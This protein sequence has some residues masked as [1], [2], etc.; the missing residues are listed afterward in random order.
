MKNIFY[1][2]IALLFTA[3][4]CQKVIDLKVNDA[5]PKMVIEAKYDAIKEIVTVQLSK[6]INVFSNEGYPQISGANIEI[7]DA[8]GVVSTLNDD[9]NGAYSLTNY[10]PQYN[11]EYTIKINVEGEVYE[12]SDYLVPVVPLDSLTTE[13]QPQSVF[14]DEGY[15]LSMNATDPVGSNFYRAI[16]KVNGEYKRDLSDQFLFDDSF[17]EGN[18]QSV[19]LFF[20]FYQLEDTV[21]IELIS[22]SEKSYVYFSELV[23]IAQGSDG[24]AA[25]ANPVSTWSKEALGSFTV[26]GYDTKTI[27]ISE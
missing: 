4:S 17:S 15:L 9:G 19:P 21:Q 25:P 6:T 3:T 5:E 27:I 1:I 8:N 13:F 10:A 7:I 11:S 14:S 23:A 2:I 26:F 18:S 24:S 12:A 22:Y 16:R 20:E